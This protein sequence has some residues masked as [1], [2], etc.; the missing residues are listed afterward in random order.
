MYIVPVAQIDSKN[1]LFIDQIA[2][3]FLHH[4]KEPDFAHTLHFIWTNSIWYE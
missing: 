3:K 1:I 4:Q 2:E